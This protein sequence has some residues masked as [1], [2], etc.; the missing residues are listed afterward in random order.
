MGSKR[1]PS[2]HR[3]ININKQP[4]WSPI[5]PN[6]HV[7]FLGSIEENRPWNS[8]YL[9]LKKQ[10]NN[11]NHIKTS[12]SKL[13]AMAETVFSVLSDDII[14]NIFLK[15]EDDPRHWA[16]LACVCTKFLSLIRDVCWKNKC[17]QTIPSVVSDLLSDSSSPPG[18]WASLHKLAVCCPGLLH[19][20]VLLE[21]SDFGLERELGP[22]E[23]YQR[24]FSP[25]TT[26]ESPET[27]LN[28]TD[29]NLNAGTSGSHCY[30]SLFDDLYSDTVYDTF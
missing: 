14:L 11:Q 9:T 8:L 2:T 13:T 24:L 17:L 10:S 28:H 12:T 30:W 25:Q 19:A 21:S 4:E 1:Y 27:C 18:G 20:G 23:N 6:P 26:R 29:A 15:L 7:L 16:R 3:K 5:Y 22:D